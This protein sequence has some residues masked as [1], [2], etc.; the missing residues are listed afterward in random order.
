MDFLTQQ[1]KK[2]V[3]HAERVT[4]TDMHSGRGLVAKSCPTLAILW[5]IKPARLL[6]PWDS[7]GK[8]TVGNYPLLQGIFLIQWSNSGLLHWRQI[9]YHLSHQTSLWVC[10]WSYPNRWGGLKPSQL[11][12]R[13]QGWPSELVPASL[14]MSVTLGIFL[15]WSDSQFP[16]LSFNYEMGLLKHHCL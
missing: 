11:K 10:R 14:L 16:L 4:L 8:N 9:L 1:G 7:P 5:T 13:S 2:R 3:R 15:K 6:C 12:A